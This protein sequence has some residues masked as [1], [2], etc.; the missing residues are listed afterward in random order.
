M[1]RHGCSD[2]RL[3]YDI[4][5]SALLVCKL[6]P[7][8]A[9]FAMLQF[10]IPSI[11]SLREGMSSVS[12][13]AVSAAGNGCRPFSCRPLALPGRDVA[14]GKSG[15]VGDFCR[16]AKIPAP[17]TPSGPRLAVQA[18]GPSTRPDEAGV[19]SP[20]CDTL[21]AVASGRRFDGSLNSSFPLTYIVPFFLSPEWEGYQFFS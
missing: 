7:S 2:V 10:R 19:T 13:P 20:R 3:P 5:E 17:R 1:F 16:V 9:D 8:R 18:A 14:R 15:D 4:P 6:T 11:G 21:P 12:L